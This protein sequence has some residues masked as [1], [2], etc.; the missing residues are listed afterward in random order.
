[1]PGPRST[2]AEGRRV[3]PSATAWSVP[4]PP[5]ATREAPTRAQPPSSGALASFVCEQ[6][7]SPLLRLSKELTWSVW[8]PAQHPW[9]YRAHP[10]VAGSPLSLAFAHS[11][12]VTPSIS[13]TRAGIHE[14][15]LERTEQVDVDL[16]LRA[17]VG[18]LAQAR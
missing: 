13:R 10:G 4:T 18:L 9:P 8:A 14:L 1:M 6:V 16:V 7:G 12:L 17:V 15:A 11:P 5:A 3:S 2:A